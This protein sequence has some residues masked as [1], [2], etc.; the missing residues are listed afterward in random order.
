MVNKWWRRSRRA[1]CRLHTAKAIFPPLGPD[2]KGSRSGVLTQGAQ[3]ESRP[4]SLGCPSLPP[5]QNRRRYGVPSPDV[6]LPLS[7]VLSSEKGL[8]EFFL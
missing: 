4:W 2:S 1:G 6:S 5:L 8:E 7:V 3:P